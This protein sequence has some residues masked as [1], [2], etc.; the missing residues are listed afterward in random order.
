MS[1]VD[2]RCVQ[3]HPELSAFVLNFKSTFTRIRQQRQRSL[4]KYAIQEM[5]I[6]P[7]EE[8]SFLFQFRASWKLCYCYCFVT[9]YPV[10][11]RRPDSRLSSTSCVWNYH[12]KF[13]VSESIFLKNIRSDHKRYTNVL[14][15]DILTNSGNYMYRCLNIEKKNIQFCPHSVFALFL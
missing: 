14:H 4:V 13:T 6:D 7:S 2:G 5:F 3:R 11:L 15:L 10:Q 9:M 12:G 1:Q 8:M